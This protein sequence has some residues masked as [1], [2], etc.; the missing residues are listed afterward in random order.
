MATHEES[1]LLGGLTRFPKPQRYGEDAGVEVRGAD[2]TGH[3]RRRRGFF[4]R[5]FMITL[6]VGGLFC[7]LSWSSTSTLL[8]QKTPE[9]A[10]SNQ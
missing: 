1:P 7:I 3:P 10:I 8:Q 9:R 6:T 2:S 4:G 5:A